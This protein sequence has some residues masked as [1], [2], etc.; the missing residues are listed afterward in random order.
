MRI[1]HP[2]RIKT[3]RSGSTNLLFGSKRVAEPSR[4]PYPCAS[5]DLS[6][7]DNSKGIQ[8]LMAEPIILEIFTDY[9]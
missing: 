1:C 3:R 4:L 6:R 5:S 7:L 8:E 9:V 2:V